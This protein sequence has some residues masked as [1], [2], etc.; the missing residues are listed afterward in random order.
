MISPLTE[1]ETQVLEAA[2]ADYAIAT[3]PGV[4]PID[5]I[6]SRR[7]AHPE[8]HLTGN[9]TQRRWIFR[10]AAALLIVLLATALL[11]QTN[12]T[13]DTADEPGAETPPPQGSEPIDLADFVVWTDDTSRR[14]PVN[15]NRLFPEDAELRPERELLRQRSSLTVEEFDAFWEGF[16]EVLDYG[17]PRPIGDISPQAWRIRGAEQLFTNVDEV[18]AADGV[19]RVENFSPCDAQTTTIFRCD[20][21]V[22]DPGFLVHEWLFALPFLAAAGIAV[23]SYRQGFD[24]E[25]K[26][27]VVLAVPV[28]FSGW[29]S[30]LIGDA[31]ASA[32]PII[33]EATIQHGQ[34]FDW[35]SFQSQEY[36]TGG[37]AT[38]IANVDPALADQL[39]SIDGL[40][41]TYFGVLALVIVALLTLAFLTGGL[42]I[43][44]SNRS[45]TQA[46]RAL[47]RRGTGA[48]LL[49]LGLPMIFT[50]LSTSQETFSALTDFLE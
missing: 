22:S 7:I 39:R 21:D 47:M 3:N 20:L 36:T 40:S 15:I 1:S 35:L 38:P 28:A 26:A 5:E 27:V 30:S 19:I 23:H 33:A 16:P 42:G 12:R 2:L 49:A 44:I 14:P 43:A 13:T 25:A 8:D 45:H 37:I 31:I 50:M 24:R 48:L 34:R 9:Q 18:L 29:V 11:T 32:E 17:V 41:L 6:S 4:A 10:A 46:Q